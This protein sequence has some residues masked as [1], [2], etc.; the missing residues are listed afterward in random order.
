MTISVPPSVNYPSPLVAI[1]TKVLNDPP[2]GNKIINCEVD[3]GTMGGA[4]KSVYFN[5]Q[6]NAT[7]NFSQI[8]AVSIDNSNCG[9]DVEFV[10]PD[11]SETMQIPA[12]SPKVI[13]EVFTNSTQFYLVG[14][15]TEP[16]DI[17]RFSLLNFVPPPVSV[18]TTQEQESA[19]PTTTDVGS[20]P[21]GT[22]QLIPA[23]ISGTLE[24]LT[25]NGAFST[26]G[27]AGF[28]WDIEDGNGT[29]ISQ[30]K[31]VQDTGIIA[32]LILSLNPIRVRFQNGLIFRWTASSMTS[33]N[34]VIANA[35]Y[36]TP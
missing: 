12:Y 29:I 36:R 26:G 11:T 9:G 15:G 7:L 10:F 16:E 23:G 34:Y 8:C 33:P 3:W 1:P 21:A 24:G 35:V 22:T 19:A 2:E 5:L 18:P 31:W 20:A 17:T 6:N 13:V 28:T 14:E 25:L 27:I 4:G 32:P 30:G